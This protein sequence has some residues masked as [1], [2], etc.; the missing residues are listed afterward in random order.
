MSKKGQISTKRIAI[1]AVLAAVLFAL[2]FLS[3]VIAGVKLT[4][5]SLPIIIAAILFGPVDGLLVAFS[6]EF[7]YQ[8][9]SFGFTATT[10][11]WLIPPILRG[12]IV[13]LGVKLF[14][15]HMAL[16]SIWNKKRPWV[17]YAVCLVAAVLVSVSN[18]LVYYVDA[19]MYG[20]YSY[21]LIWGVA[22]VRIL[23]NLLSTFICATVAIPILQAV[24]HTG[25]CS[26]NIGIKAQKQ[27]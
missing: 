8:M 1:D 7:I 10:L 5:S 24:V 12:L 2:S 20:Y 6:G 21:E 27:A 19:K 25:I 3:P 13:G 26:Q 16:T 18:T 15:R 11:L 17:Y 14:P 22:G 23:T 9:L 4:F